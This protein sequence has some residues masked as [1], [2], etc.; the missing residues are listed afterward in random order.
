MQG[1]CLM[2]VFNV[3]KNSKEYY[4]NNNRHYQKEFESIRLCIFIVYS[5]VSARICYAVAQYFNLL[6]FNIYIN[7]HFLWFFMSFNDIY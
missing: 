5:D 1:Y 4:E 2:P 6:F 3:T 7:M